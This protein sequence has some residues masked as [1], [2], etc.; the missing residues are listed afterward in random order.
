MGGKLV[1]AGERKTGD[2]ELTR[3][4]PE[5][6]RIGRTIKSSVEK[7]RGSKEWLR[8]VDGGYKKLDGLPN[9]S[10][11]DPKEGLQVERI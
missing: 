6:T 1:Y 5:Q 3:R 11:V 2:C 8:G 4:K 7:K 9:A 10:C